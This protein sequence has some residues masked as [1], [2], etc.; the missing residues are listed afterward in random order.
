V[1]A[2]AVMEAAV[3]AH[4]GTDDEREHFGVATGGAGPGGAVGKIV[5]KHG[6]NPASLALEI[7]ESVVIKDAS[8]IIDVLHAF[9]RLGVK[10]HM[11][12]SAQ[13]IRR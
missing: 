7:T 11:E 5:L 10:L 2:V 6:I 3:P 4:G 1:P 13:G 12:T 8:A 9:R